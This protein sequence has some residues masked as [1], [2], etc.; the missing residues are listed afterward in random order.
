LYLDKSDLSLKEN[1]DELEQ[2]FEKGFVEKTEFFLSG[3]KKVSFYLISKK[4]EDW[5]ASL[6]A[7]LPSTD[8][9]LED[10]NNIYY[11]SST[12]YYDDSIEERQSHIDMMEK[13]IKS[14]KFSD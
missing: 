9:F 3:N 13:A 5:P 12:S 6:D 7:F 1:M 14:I 2:M 10:E 8:A 11:F 4:N